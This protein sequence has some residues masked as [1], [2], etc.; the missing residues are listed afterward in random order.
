MNDTQKKLTTHRK[1]TEE[2]I[3]SMAVLLS[4]KKGVM[5]HF[6]LM[7]VWMKA[8]KKIVTLIFI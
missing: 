8:E 3:R 7:V 4:G 1:C 6:V 2:N 5:G